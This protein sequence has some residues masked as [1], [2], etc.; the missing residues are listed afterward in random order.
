M[1]NRQGRTSFLIFD[2]DMGQMVNQTE[3]P[4][5]T[6]GIVD[7]SQFKYRCEV[8]SKSFQKRASFVIHQRT[9]TGERPFVCQICK[10][11]F[12]HKHH[13]KI[14]SG[15]HLVQKPFPC[16]LCDQRFCS[17]HSLQRHCAHKHQFMDITIFKSIFFVT[18]L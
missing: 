14:H 8:C 13:L 5:S 18:Y 4:L 15:V 10:K 1:D 7:S 12:R 9:H 17:K 16:H 3:Y 11:A 2:N 6:F